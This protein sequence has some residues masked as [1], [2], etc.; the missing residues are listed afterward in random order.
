V[1]LTTGVLLA[2]LPS[3]A[4]DIAG[5]LLAPEVSCQTYL[6]GAVLALPARPDGLAGAA[7]DG[8]PVASVAGTLFVTHLPRPDLEDVVTCFGTVA[9]GSEVLDR[10]EEGDVIERVERVE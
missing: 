1:D 9:L 10:V 2:G 5:R 3:A 4:G 7:A 6:R 8:K